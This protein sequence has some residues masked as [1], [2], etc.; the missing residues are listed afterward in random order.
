MVQ[1]SFEIGGKRVSGLQFCHDF[2][3]KLK[4]NSLLQEVPGEKTQVHKDFFNKDK[5]QNKDEYPIYS[6]NPHFVENLT[7]LLSN[8]LKLDHLKF[9]KF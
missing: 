3:T 5:T 7:F 8:N 4:K 1:D 9:K 6:L 2:V